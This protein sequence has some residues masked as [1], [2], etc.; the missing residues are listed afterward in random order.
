MNPNE[1]PFSCH[2]HMLRH[3]PMRGALVI[4]IV[5]KYLEEGV[6]MPVTL[7]D[8][9]REFLKSHG[10]ARMQHLS[11]EERV[12]GLPTEELERLLRER[13]AAEATGAKPKKSGKPGRGSSKR[14]T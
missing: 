8:L 3:S 2:Y 12:A 11:P 10:P 6:S 13:R 9:Y 4:V 5:A 7:D 14:G 1:E